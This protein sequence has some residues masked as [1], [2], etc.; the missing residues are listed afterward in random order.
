MFTET[1]KVYT[2]RSQAE[3]NENEEFYEVWLKQLEEYQ[4]RDM[5][6]SIF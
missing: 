1:Y 4:M 6:G 2:P 5:D 3:E